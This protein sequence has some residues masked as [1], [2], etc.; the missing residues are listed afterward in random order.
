M[1]SSSEKI[2]SSICIKNSCDDVPN[3]A[4]AGQFRQQQHGFP[5]A[6]RFNDKDPE[7]RF[8]IEGAWLLAPTRHGAH[9]WEGGTRLLHFVKGNWMRNWEVACSYSKPKQ[10]SK[11]R[12]HSSD[13]CSVLGI[14]VFRTRLTVYR[15]HPKNHWELSHGFVDG[16][17]GHHERRVWHLRVEPF[18]AC[19]DQHPLL[20]KSQF[21]CSYK[22][23]FWAIWITIAYP[24][25][26]NNGS[27]LS[28]S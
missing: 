9:N 14:S 12:L 26:I 2:C 25:L 23:K 27:T 24:F 17:I 4:G 20:V 28:R 1:T 3:I 10:K 21:Y 13:N 5:M 8:G 16:K 19:C 22:P 11:I 15:E 18:R 6:C 7:Y